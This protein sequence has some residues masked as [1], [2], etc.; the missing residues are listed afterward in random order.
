ME[1]EEARKMSIEGKDTDGRRNALNETGGRI[2]RPKYRVEMIGHL[3]AVLATIL[4]QR[5]IVGIWISLL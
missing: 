1:N 3:N 5:G 4:R 2:P